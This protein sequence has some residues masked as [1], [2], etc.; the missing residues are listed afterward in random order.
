V[1]NKKMFVK[2]PATEKKVSDNRDKQDG[3]THASNKK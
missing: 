2:T 1:A 3:Q